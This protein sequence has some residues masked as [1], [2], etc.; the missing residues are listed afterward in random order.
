M[1]RRT[2]FRNAATG[3]I[4]VPLGAFA[5]QQGKF[6]RVGSASD[7]WETYRSKRGDF[8]VDHPVTWTV[9]EQVDAGG[10]AGDSLGRNIEVDENPLMVDVNTSRAATFGSANLVAWHGALSLRASSYDRLRVCGRLLESLPGDI[11]CNIRS[12]IHGAA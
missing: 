4:A 12:E 5:Q 2:F 8:T 9:E 11:L 10:N 1:N 3:V 7:G 6:W